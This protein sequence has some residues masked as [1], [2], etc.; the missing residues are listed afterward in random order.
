MG[1]LGFAP[2]EATVAS[3]IYDNLNSYTT[4]KR[5]S[6]LAPEIMVILLKP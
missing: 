3:R 4:P 2:D 6:L 5:R 1:R